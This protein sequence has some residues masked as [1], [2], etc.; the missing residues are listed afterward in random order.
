[1]FQTTKNIFSLSLSF[2]HGC[3]RFITQTPF[4]LI[5]PRNRAMRCCVDHIYDS[6]IAKKPC[7]H[8]SSTND[9]KQE[10]SK[11]TCSK[12]YVWKREHCFHVSSFVVPSMHPPFF[13]TACVPLGQPLAC[14]CRFAGSYELAVLLTW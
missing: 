7:F 3:L 2:L 8:C 13:S 9:R 10:V 11:T 1:M 4:F 5:T 6:L 12:G 14:P